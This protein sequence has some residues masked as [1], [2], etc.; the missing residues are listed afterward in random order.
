MAKG[1]KKKEIAGE[2]KKI[3]ERKYTQMEKL[4]DSRSLAN[5]HATFITFNPIVKVPHLLLNLCHNLFNCDTIE[6]LDYFK[7]NEKS[8]N[9]FR[10][11]ILF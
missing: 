2:K 1:L 4:C 3:S 7:C 8:Q 9:V 5:T 11:C 10:Y 6:K